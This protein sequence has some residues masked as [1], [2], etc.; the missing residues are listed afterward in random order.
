MEFDVLFLELENIFRVL[1]IF[2]GCIDRLPSGDYATVFDLFGCHYE[3]LRLV[4]EEH[5]DVSEQAGM[6]LQ[7]FAIH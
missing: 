1:L 7:R 4:I 2:L 5:L 3:F 6:G